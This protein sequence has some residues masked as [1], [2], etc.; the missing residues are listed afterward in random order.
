MAE[1]NGRAPT[2]MPTSFW[3][4]AETKE[5]LDLLVLERGLSRSKIVTI[6]IHAMAERDAEGEMREVRR[7]V[8]ELSKAVK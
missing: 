2:T 4:D 5:T 1:D 6:A 8:S 7:L 3:L